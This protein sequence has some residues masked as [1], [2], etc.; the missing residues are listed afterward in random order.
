MKYFLPLWLL[1][2]VIGCKN[3]EGEP[4]FK[5]V[6]QLQLSGTAKKT[7]KI[8][9]AFA[10]HNPAEKEVWTFVSLMADI[11][12]EGKDVGTYVYTNNVAIKSGSEFKVPLLQSVDTDK[13]PLN[14]GAS[15]ESVAVRLK[16][17]VLLVNDKGDKLKVPFDQTET[18]EAR[19]QRDNK[20]NEREERKEEKKL[21][22]ELRKL[23]KE[24]LKLEKSVQ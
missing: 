19:I 16:G 12:I 15:A 22:K 4:Q 8:K 23:Q 2:T 21:R 3:K 9:G 7:A 11:S 13:L 10:F 1:L 18:I 6:Y 14:E 24:Q 17:H 20:K 5:T